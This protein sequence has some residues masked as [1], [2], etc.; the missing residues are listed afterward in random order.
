M[1]LYWDIQVY[2]FS[3]LCR[4][5]RSMRRHWTSDPEVTRSL[6]SDPSVVMRHC[7]ELLV[8]TPFIQWHCVL[9]AEALKRF[10]VVAGLMCGIAT[11][12]FTSTEM[13]HQD[14]IDTDVVAEASEVALDEDMVIEYDTLRCFA[15]SRAP[16]GRYTF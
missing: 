9:V 14:S 4:L 10:P 16:T 15:V 3:R 1:Q 6:H 12:L 11:G 5:F 8:R 2:L 7:C 13:V